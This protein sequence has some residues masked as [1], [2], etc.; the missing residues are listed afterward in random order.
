MIKQL[1]SK[2]KALNIE[3][4][5]NLKTE[6]FSDFILTYKSEK[7]IGY[8]WSR[9]NM[10]EIV[11]F[12]G[13][14]SPSMIAKNVWLTTKMDEYG[15]NF[16]EVIDLFQFAISKNYYWFCPP[17]NQALVGSS[18]PALVD[19]SPLI[20]SLKIYLEANFDPKVFIG[21][22]NKWDMF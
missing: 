7:I 5:K 13:S 10:N 3:I 20:N 1:N 4:K 6:G 2:L 21:K 19:E 17:T 11:G 12:M 8:G 22:D 14:A 18:C 9:E 16:E 15:L